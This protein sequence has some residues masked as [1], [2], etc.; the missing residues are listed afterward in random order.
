MYSIKDLFSQKKKGKLLIT[1]ALNEQHF[2]HLQL[3]LMNKN[4]L[5]FIKRKT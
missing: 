2:V 1:R 5:H 3:K 4:I